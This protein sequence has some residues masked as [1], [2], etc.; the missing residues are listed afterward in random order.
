MSLEDWQPPRCRHGSILL[1]CIEEP[2]PDQDAYLTQQWAQMDQWQ[3]AQRDAASDIVR[4]LSQPPLPSELASVATPGVA[5]QSVDTDLAY[6]KPEVGSLPC[7]SCG[8]F[9]YD[10]D[11]DMCQW[12]PHGSM[13]SGLTWPV[14]IAVLATLG[15]IALSIVQGWW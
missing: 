5:S 10:P 11:M 1:A 13:I 6:R 2:C 4:S 15:V 3:A 14:R 9:S 8:A 12:C 7:P